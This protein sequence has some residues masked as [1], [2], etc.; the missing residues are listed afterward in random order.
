MQVL[1]ERRFTCGST[2]TNQKSFVP[3]RAIDAVVLGPRIKHEKPTRA[4]NK[5][6]TPVWR[7]KLEPG[8]LKLMWL[9][10][11]FWNSYQNSCHHS[12][13]NLFFIWDWMLALSFFGDLFVGHQVRAAPPQPWPWSLAP[14][15]LPLTRVRLR[16][17]PF[18]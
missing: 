5:K 2:Y 1:Q 7:S 15:S 4:H 17:S 16:H 3:E 8:W 12:F 11:G 6:R 9:A 13:Q 14:L 18:A 10:L